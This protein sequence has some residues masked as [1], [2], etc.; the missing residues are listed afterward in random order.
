MNWSGDSCPLE[1]GHGSMPHGTGLETDL[2]S[3]RRGGKASTSPQDISMQARKRRPPVG[4]HI[5]AIM[6][7]IKVLG[8]PASCQGRSQALS[9]KPSH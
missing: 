8:A 6:G 9:I 3:R 1:E 5:I 2:N 7:P 4:G